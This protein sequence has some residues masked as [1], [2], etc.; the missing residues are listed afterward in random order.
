[1]H[2]LCLGVMKGLMEKWIGK[3][4]NQAK[5]KNAQI[6]Q[7]KK[8]MDS[9]KPMIP[10]EFQRKNFDLDF[11]NTWKA[12]QF[13][14]VLLYGGPIIL[15]YILPVSTYKHFM[16]FSC[17]CRILLSKKLATTHVKTA[18]LYLQKFVLL[19]PSIYGS[20][21]HTINVHN[22][23]HIADDVE[24]MNADLSVYSAFPFESYLGV[25]KYLVR[26]PN[27]PLVQ[28]LNRLEELD[29]LS[30]Q[31]MKPQK[32]INLNISGKKSSTDNVLNKIEL[33]GPILS[34]TCPD[35]IVRLK[36]ETYMKID[37]ILISKTDDST[38][39]KL[40][41]RGRVIKCRGSAFNYPQKSV[42]FGIIELGATVEATK[43]ISI[44]KVLNKVL[45]LNIE[46]KQFG[47]NFL[48]A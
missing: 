4:R 21:C 33:N 18:R 43:I 29:S 16:L 32:I 2:L 37:E 8:I 19:M 31:K 24:F 23:I 20:R 5:L 25:I 34:K 7:W 11:W 40:H 42:F 46:G 44:D 17:A 36:S 15:K 28:V 38:I 1:M 48:H 3:K 13:R 12:T 45:L 39:N 9:I 10:S 47:L 30:S 41:L 22:L 26:T 27:K 6:T 14:F 35:N